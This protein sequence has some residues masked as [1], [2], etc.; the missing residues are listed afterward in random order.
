[1][2][3][4]RFLFIFIFFPLALICCNK[5]GS[6]NGNP[7]KESAQIF[8]Q[9]TEYTVEIKGYY[10]HDHKSF[11]QGL[12]WQNGL[13]YESTGL[14][15]KSY[16]RIWNPKTG[17]IIRQADLASKYFGEGITIYGKKIYQLTWQNKICK[18]Y[19]SETLAPISE[20][21]YDGEGWGI[22]TIGNNLVMSDGSNILRFINPENFAVTKELP[23]SDGF[24]PVI[25]LNELEII[26]GEIWAN[27]W[28]STKIAIIN[29]DNGIVRAFVDLG[30][31]F[32][33]L[34]QDY[35]DID[36]LNGIAWDSENNKIYVTGK[37]WNKVFEITLN[38]K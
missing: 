16:I 24:S 22:T 15:G 14:N 37:L 34:N 3:L 32:E 10:D 28:Q 6:E 30:Y 36:V 20:F 1:M 11:T 21:K 7:K 19:N 12:F 4:N 5:G 29:P 35:R 17:K 31:L 23:V 2:L 13:F 38:E 9:P 25:N 18:V 8:K 26:N 33:N 27:I